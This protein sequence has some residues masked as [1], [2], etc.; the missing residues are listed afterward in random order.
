MI[1]WQ[2]ACCSVLRSLIL[3]LTMS[4]LLLTIDRLGWSNGKQSSVRCS[5]VRV[6]WN[7][8]T[9]VSAADEGDGPTLAPSP[10][11]AVLPRN[12]VDAA[13]MPAPTPR[14]NSRRESGTDTQSGQSDSFIFRSLTSAMGVVLLG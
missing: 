3:G 14:T 7:R 9:A 5:L 12:G 1:S 13:R 4:Q 2:R 8:A 6:L 11:T 10:A